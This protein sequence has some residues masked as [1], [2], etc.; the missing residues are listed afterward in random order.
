MAGLVVL[1]SIVVVGGWVALSRIGVFWN[2]PGP[3][4]LPSEI[5]RR[6]FLASAQDGTAI[7][8]IIE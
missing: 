7:I 6:L 1:E 8:I 2:G 3:P 5:R 4:K